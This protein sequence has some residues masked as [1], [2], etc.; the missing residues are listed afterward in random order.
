[1]N[2]RLKEKYPSDA[3]LFEFVFNG[4]S[5]CVYASETPCGVVICD[6]LVLV[7]LRVDGKT[8]YM[9]TEQGLEGGMHTKALGGRSNGSISQERWLRFCLVPSAQCYVYTGPPSLRQLERGGG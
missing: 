9:E 6:A 2:G 8:L 5:K 3:T 7:Q 1:M 4:S